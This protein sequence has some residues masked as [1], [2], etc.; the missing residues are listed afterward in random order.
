MWILNDLE[1]W[2]KGHMKKN[3]KVRKKNVPIYIDPLPKK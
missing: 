2:V 3:K 1:K